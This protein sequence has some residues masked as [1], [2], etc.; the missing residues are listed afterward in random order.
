MKTSEFRWSGNPFVISA[1]S[2]RKLDLKIRIK[3]DGLQKA[4]SIRYAVT[5]TF[6]GVLDRC[7]WKSQLPLTEQLQ[8]RTHA[9]S[10]ESELF[11]YPIKNA[12]AATSREAATSLLVGL[13]AMCTKSCYV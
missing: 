3:V 1:G 2:L 9:A 11:T 7:Q 10:S 6:L 5:R 12:E 8:V 13:P 4:S